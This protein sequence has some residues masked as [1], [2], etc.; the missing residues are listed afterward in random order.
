MTDEAPL[1]TFYSKDD[2]YSS[3]PPSANRPALEFRYSFL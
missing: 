1:P 3:L 2:L